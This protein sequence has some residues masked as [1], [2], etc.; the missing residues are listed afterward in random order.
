MVIAAHAGL[1]ASSSNDD[2]DADPELEPLG[3]VEP[4]G[5]STHALLQLGGAADGVDDA[6]E[7][8]QQPVAGGLDDPSAMFGNRGVDELAAVRAETEEGSLL[9]RLHEPAVSHRVG[10][11]DCSE[12]PFNTAGRHSAPSIFRE[13]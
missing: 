3:C 8:R 12:S 6:R 7:L 9:I 11:E 10:G 13:S 5:A 2:R 1:S 4:G